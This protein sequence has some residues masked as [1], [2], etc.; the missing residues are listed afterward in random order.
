MIEKTAKIDARGQ[1]LPVPGLARP[2][3]RGLSNSE[4]RRFLLSRRIQ[5]Q[6]FPI[7]AASSPSL[8]VASDMLNGAG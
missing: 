1:K 4:A 6:G 3:W 2:F 7:F 5:R 8:R